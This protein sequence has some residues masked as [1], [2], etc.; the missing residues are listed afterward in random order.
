M[1]TV[2][3]IGDVEDP[4][5]D[6]VNSVFVLSAENVFQCLPEGRLDV[7]DVGEKGDNES[8]L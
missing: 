5:D 6:P 1:F 4:L 7:V 2:Y 3:R 8:E